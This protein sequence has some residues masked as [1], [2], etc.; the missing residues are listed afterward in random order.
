VHCGDRS[1]PRANLTDRGA[2]AAAS[3][4]TLGVG[5]GDVM[6]VLLRNEPGVLEVLAAVRRL[7]AQRLMI[8]WHLG[9][10]EV[11]AILAATEPRVLV[12]HEDF[13]SAL[14]PMLQAWPSLVIAVLD[15]PTEV[16]RAY[17]I[18]LAS[19]P[20]DGRTHRWTDLVAA[21][22]GPLE[23]VNP[24]S[25]VLTL[26]SGST[27]R[28][29]L[30]SWTG[31]PQS[32]RRARAYTANRPPIRT[33]IVTAPLYH[34]A[35]FGVFMHAT[36]A[37]ANLVLL[38]KFDAEA[39]LQAVERHRVNHA[40]AVPTMFVRLLKLPPAIRARYD[41]SSLDQVV[42]TGAPCPPA[43]KRQMIDWLGPV[44]WETYGCSETS[45]I[46]CCS[47]AEWLARP[48]SVGRPF[49][50][51]VIVD[52]SGDPVPTG[53][54]GRIYVDVSGISS[55]SGAG[56]CLDVRTI[57]ERPHL[58]PGDMGYLDD[59]GYLYLVGRADGLINTGRVKVYPREIEDELIRHPEVR[60]C[61]VFA[62]PDAEFG[63]IIGVAVDAESPS[64][65]TSGDLRD[66]LAPRISEHKIP[67]AVWA[68]PR[69]LRLDNGKLNR[70][71]L[72]RLI[73]SPTTAG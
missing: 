9:T 11:Q 40:Y 1:Q 16:L 65:L 2:R 49:V 15:T 22:E 66:F 3:L 39:F 31:G 19:G 57:S 25:P 48:G 70:Q 71:A 50:P 20:I 24:S 35:Q 42:H 32:A 26:T 28:P 5:A 52:E 18:S 51:V 23:T 8:P 36:N 44:I 7:G 33:S 12:L 34:G 53:Q 41:V 45:A 14:W 59:D 67:V 10:A 58:A 27:G 56:D 47:S 38:P 21:A 60:D 68:M 55:V 37:E 29:K 46:A 62:V 69:G 43:V 61:A 72:A 6:A 13:L 64:G 63:Q 4:A 17:D 30:V 54:T 73:E